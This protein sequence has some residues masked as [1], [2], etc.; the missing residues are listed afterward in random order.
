M[1]QVS[2]KS[3]TRLGAAGS[4]FSLFKC[5]LVL[6][7][8]GTQALMSHI[9]QHLNDKMKR[10]LAEMVGAGTYQMPPRHKCHHIQR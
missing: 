5:L 8:Q 6:L 2:I 7:L 10:S 1:E 4:H 3:R 9:L